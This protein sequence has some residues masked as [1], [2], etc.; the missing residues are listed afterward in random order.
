MDA[1]PDVS[2]AFAE[3]PTGSSGEPVTINYTAAYGIGADSVNKDQA[4]VLAQYLAGPEGMQKWTE[5]GIAVPSRTDVPTP[6]GFEVIVAGAEYARPGSGF[7]PS[8]P[9]VLKAFGDEFTKQITDKSYDAA[10]VSAA[11]KAK[12]DEVLG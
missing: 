2:W 10:A 4:W 7:M 6:E 5:G 3:M 12:I 8:Y 9:D 1:F 11:T